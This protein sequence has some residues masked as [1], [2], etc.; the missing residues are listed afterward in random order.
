MRSM[1]IIN[2]IDDDFVFRCPKYD[3][4]GEIESEMR[5]RGLPLTVLK[6]PLSYEYL[7]NTFIP[8]KMGQ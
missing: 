5:A 4:K 8:Q 3:G 7:V 1:Y 6:L 2:Y